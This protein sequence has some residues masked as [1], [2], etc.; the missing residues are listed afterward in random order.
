MTL[1]RITVLHERTSD[2]KGAEEPFTPV[3]ADR[4]TKLGPVHPALAETLQAYGELPRRTG[5]ER[6]RW[7][8][9]PRRFA[10]NWAW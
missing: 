5:R 8:N 2:L 1:H 9:V 3:L 6:D 4:E 10:T 7:R